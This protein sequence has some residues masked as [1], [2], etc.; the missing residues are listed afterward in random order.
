MGTITLAGKTIEVDEEGFLKDRT[1]WSEEIAMEMA[2][3]DKCDLMPDH[4]EVINFQ[5]EFFEEHR[6]GLLFTRSDR[7]TF[8]KKLG[9]DKGNI[10]YLYELF[11]YGANQANRYA[12]LYKVVGTV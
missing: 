7:K 11:P 3:L 2:R 9:P 10:K 4:W 12:G 5:R 8:D 6:V 1:V